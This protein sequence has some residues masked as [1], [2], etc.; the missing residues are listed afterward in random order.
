MREGGGGG[1]RG[2]AEQKGGQGQSWQ[3]RRGFRDRAATGMITPLHDQEERGEIDS[4]GE[5]ERGYQ[6]IASGQKVFPGV[7]FTFSR[8]SYPERLN[9][10]S[11]Q[12]P[13]KQAC[14]SDLSKDTTS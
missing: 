5:Q 4:R 14:S 2:R 11:G 3:S 7:T 9:V 6:G 12:F 13:P 10:S 1:G 8:R